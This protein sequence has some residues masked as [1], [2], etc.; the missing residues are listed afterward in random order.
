MF[1]RFYEKLPGSFVIGFVDIHQTNIVWSKFLQLNI[2]FPPQSI[3]VTDGS[4]FVHSS[5]FDQ[6]IFVH[7][8]CEWD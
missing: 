6:F 7:S 3:R 8:E 4:I 1:H 5:M 2:S